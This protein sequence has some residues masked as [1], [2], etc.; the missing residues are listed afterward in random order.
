VQNLQGKSSL[1][2]YQLI[3]SA[4]NERQTQAIASHIEDTMRVKKLGK[5][6]A[7]EGKQTGHWIL[8]DY[9]DVMV[10]IFL[11]GIRDYYAIERLWPEA[12]MSQFGQA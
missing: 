6:I 2:D 3:C 1:C 11:E 4:S 5:P 10:H 12:P 9:G 7:I 8:M